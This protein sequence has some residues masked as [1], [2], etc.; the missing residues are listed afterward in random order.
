MAGFD[1][2]D[3]GPGPRPPAPAIDPN[4]FPPEVFRFLDD[5]QAVSAAPARGSPKGG[6][7]LAADD[8]RKQTMFKLRY[9]HFSDKDN[10][11]NSHLVADGPSRI[12]I[13]RFP[14]EVQPLLR[15]AV[16][17]KHRASYVD[18]NDLVT[19]FSLYKEIVD[20]PDSIPISVL[21]RELHGKVE[22]FDVDGNGLIS[23]DE[24]AAA[25]ELYQAS[26]RKQR[27]YLVA[28]VASFAFILV[29][30]GT[31]GGLVY[32]VVEGTKE[33]HTGSAGVTTSAANASSVAM[34]GTVDV[35]RVFAEKD[36]KRNQ[37]FAED[38]KNGRIPI[39]ASGTDYGKTPEAVQLY[40]LD[41]AGGGG[42][43]GAY[44]FKL[45]A[46]AREDQVVALCKV[47][48]QYGAACM[49]TGS[50][51]ETA[52]VLVRG[53]RAQVE[54][55]RSRIQRDAG[56]L[57][58]R[59][60]PNPHMGCPNEYT[61]I[62]IEELVNLEVPVHHV[63][64]EVHLHDADAH[65]RRLAAIEH[66]ILRTPQ[67]RLHRQ[68]KAPNAT[69]GAGARRDLRYLAANGEPAMPAGEMP[70]ESCYSAS[71]AGASYRGG[72]NA[73]RAPDAAGA[74]AAFPCEPWDELRMKHA[75]T[76]FFSRSDGGDVDDGVLAG[77][78]CRAPPGSPFDRPWCFYKADDGS[79]KL[80]TC[81]LPSCESEA[82]AASG[83]DRLFGLDDWSWGLERVQKVVH[84][85]AEVDR[86]NVVLVAQTGA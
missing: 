44:S 5:G 55:T 85:R 46:G 48:E 2:W 69:H 9:S 74:M 38:L 25:A 47:V 77:N 83:D 3:S 58:P 28:L 86:G 81:A 35:R 65:R 23:P 60:Y 30:L 78:A 15:E 84:L 68:R 79:V 59:F 12:D 31:V 39:L 75:G 19:I 11:L 36:A 14:E 61:V 43:T 37:Q 66:L 72:A 20:H 82:S 26:Q 4:D 41:A 27:R 67:G 51:S 76:M 52:Q 62:T 17:G 32:A 56:C 40:G 24:L 7:A 18:M 34:Y 63:S 8:K 29:C 45:A 22:A 6:G 16:A 49:N 42:P 80:H 13:A 70:Q 71:D 73:V 54:S 64:E 53:S 57:D 10:T 33:T 50:A 21:P 1:R